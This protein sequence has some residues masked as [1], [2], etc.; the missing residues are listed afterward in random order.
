MMLSR[1]SGEL[2]PNAATTAVTRLTRLSIG[3]LLALFVFGPVTA[4]QSAVVP[5]A[6]G[7][8]GL[9]VQDRSHDNDNPDNTL[10]ALYQI[11][12]TGTASVP[13]SSLTMRYWFT[14][15]TPAD[16]LVFECDYAQVDRANI[17][18]RFVA[19]PA[20]VTKANTYVEIGFKAAAGSL[21]PGQGSGE[22]QTRVHHVNW[23]NFTTTDSYSFIADP[24]FVYK[25]TQTVTLY[26]NGVLIWGVEPA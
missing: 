17:T 13:L 14:N 1:G 11:A 8:S 16:P 20:P 10:Y 23:S 24:S 15:E 21:A 9:K 25:D 2:G 4:A 6:Q 19:L 22:V 26:L 18:A 12:N 7:D 5:A 3:L